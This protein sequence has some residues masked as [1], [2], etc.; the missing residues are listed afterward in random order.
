MATTDQEANGFG[1]R[2]DGAKLRFRDA[3]TYAYFAGMSTY[4]DAERAYRAGRI[5]ERDWRACQLARE[6]SA[7]LFSSTRQDR[8]FDRLGPA[9]YSRRFGRARRLIRQYV[10]KR[11]AYCKDNGSANEPA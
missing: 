11:F 5:S 7:P 4:A 2:I 10:S 8:A 3:A 9:A 6:W 1:I